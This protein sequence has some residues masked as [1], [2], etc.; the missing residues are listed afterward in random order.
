VPGM[1]NGPA[2]RAAVGDD[3]DALRRLALDNHMFTPDAM[4]GFEEILSGSLDGSLEDH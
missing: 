2:V 3:V 4:G 1:G